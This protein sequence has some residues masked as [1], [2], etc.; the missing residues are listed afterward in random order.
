MSVGTFGGHCITGDH[1][2]QQDALVVAA[3]DAAELQAMPCHHSN[4]S[5]LGVLKHGEC[6]VTLGPMRTCC[7]LA[8]LLQVGRWG[9]EDLSNLCS[10]SEGAGPSAPAL[11]DYQTEGQ[12]EPRQPPCCCSAWHPACRSSPSLR[13]LLSYHCFKSLTVTQS[14]EDK[15]AC[16]M[17]EQDQKKV[18]S[19]QL[20]Y[21]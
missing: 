18:K 12:A 15:T 16:T 3:L 5:P 1:C 4:A 19:N 14:F 11:P 2:L 9:C 7:G 20:I 8:T 6:A 17:R 10:G 21:Y 13:W